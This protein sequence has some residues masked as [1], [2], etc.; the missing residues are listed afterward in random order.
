MHGI[1]G[2][3][4]PAWFTLTRRLS[5]VEI[6]HVDLD[7]GYRVGDWPDSFVAERLPGSPSRSPAGTT[8]PP[9]WSR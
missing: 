4:H 6:H 9:A 2:K 5:E 8:R 3:A 1:H 7:I